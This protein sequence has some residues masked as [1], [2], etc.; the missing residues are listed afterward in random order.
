MNLGKKK[1]LAAK[2]LNVGKKRIVFLEPR[3]EEIKEAITKQDIKDL[4]KEGFI[5]IKPIKGRRKIK[6]R[7]TRRGPG[8]IKKKIKNRKQ[9]YVKI[10][11]K[12]RNYLKELKS[13]GKISNE[14]FWELRKKIRMRIFRS[15]THL[16]E[17]LVNIEKINLNKKIES[18]KPKSTKKKETKSKSK[19][20]KQ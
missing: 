1:I 19:I 10:T 6:K 12:L 11:R 17:Y 20:K 5:S 2:A 7:K 4:Y 14:L 18:D 9:V 16:K 15:K 8:K 13:Q 3:L